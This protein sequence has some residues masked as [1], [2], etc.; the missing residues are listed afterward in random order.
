[1]FNSPSPKPPSVYK[2][3][4]QK[5]PCLCVPLVSEYWS[6]MPGHSSSCRQIMTFL[7]PPIPHLHSSL[8]QNPCSQRARSK[9][10]SPR[11][12]AAQR[13]GRTTTAALPHDS[14]R[15]AAAPCAG[16]AR[17][18][19]GWRGTSATHSERRHLARATRGT[20]GTVCTP[21]RSQPRARAMTG[22]PRGNRARSS[23]SPPTRHG[24]RRCAVPASSVWS[25]SYASD[26]A[27]NLRICS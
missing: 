18:R 27:R 8:P 4:L 10:Q 21:R 20:S 7:F 24:K 1:M 23:P 12:T 22:M 2:K 19:R 15:A 17:I 16:P 25:A 3:R 5:A 13:A 14:H 26:N 6:G 9:Y 11:H